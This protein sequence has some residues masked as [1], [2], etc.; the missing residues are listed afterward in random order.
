MGAASG[1]HWIACLGL[2]TGLLACGPGPEPGVERVAAPDADASSQVLART[3]FRAITV[4]DVEGFVG[5]L[6]SG[7]RPDPELSVAEHYRQLARRLAVEE[8][9]LSEALEAGA[10]RDPEVKSLGH[11]Y[12]RL[13][14][15]E[16]YLA[17]QDLPEPISEESVRARFE[18]D[19][20]RFEQGEKR[21]VG[22]IF[23]RHDESG[24]R[25]VTHE[26]LEAIRREIL[27]GRPFELMAREHSESETR[28]DDGLLG[29]V[30]RGF[31]PQDFDRVVFALTPETPSE[32][33]LTADGGHLF[34]VHNV[35]EAREVTYEDVRELL[36]RELQLDRQLDR[37]RRAAAKLPM[38][39]GARIVD[40]EQISSL[41]A[42]APADRILLSLGDYTFN[43]GQLRE[44]TRDAARQLGDLADA[45]LPVRLFEEL[46]LREVVY[47]HMLAEE[48]AGHSY[49]LPV[50]QLEEARRRQLVDH[51]ARRKMRK[52]LA[53]DPDQLEQYRAANALR[54]SSPL[55]FE[56]RRLVVPISDQGPAVMARLERARDALDRG[57]LNLEALA[58]ELDGAVRQVGPISLVQLQAVDPPAVRFAALLKPGEHSPPYRAAAGLS[59]FAVI[60]RVEPRPLPLGRVREQVIDALLEQRAAQLFEQIASE[61]L[62][63]AGF[64]IVES[65]LAEL[66]GS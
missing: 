38:P 58:R 18:Q 35:L 61:M 31:F 65:A 37:L 44:Q 51:F 48:R 1:A 24:A 41:V 14:Y 11:P 54:F 36:R 64:E 2:A 42:G 12:R 52:R 7:Y 26:R 16:H 9:L 50:Q 17:S 45:E 53:G 66:G 13:V 4:A 19:K 27:G 25:Q 23:L 63:A 29:V 3:S 39:E 5:R 46:R 40:D 55:G 15:S 34:Y 21:R 30:E 6:G 10:E 8:L 60:E 47:Q 56:L 57:E 43:V 59:M 28:H 20:T 62:G 32:V 33:Y 49:D 22:H